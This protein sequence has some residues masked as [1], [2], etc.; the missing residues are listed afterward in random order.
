MVSYLKLLFLFFGVI[1]KYELLSMKVFVILV[2]FSLFN[3]VVKL[4][5]I[6]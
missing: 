5:N 2:E 1:M 3:N 4:F 6:T